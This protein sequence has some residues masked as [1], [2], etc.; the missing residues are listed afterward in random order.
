MIY[1]D[2]PKEN[3]FVAYP[4]IV[5]KKTI[6]DGEYVVINSLESLYC[7]I[8]E[9]DVL[10][11]NSIRCICNHGFHRDVVFNCNIASLDKK[12]NLFIVRFE[13]EQ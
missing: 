11:K 13:N 8:V 2:M 12:G 10:S 6:L 3:R 4:D 9:V 1:F 7:R 5:V